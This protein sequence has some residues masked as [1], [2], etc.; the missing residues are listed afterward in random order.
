VKYVYLLGL[1]VFNL[2]HKK[3]RDRMCVSAERVK[4][5]THLEAKTGVTHKGCETDL[6]YDLTHLGD[7]DK[8]SD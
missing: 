6:K 4:L 2:S 1:V 3:V 7:S 8:N 5:G